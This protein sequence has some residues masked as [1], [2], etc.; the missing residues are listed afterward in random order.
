MFSAALLLSM[1]KLCS[2]VN[3]GSCFRVGKKR[4]KGPVNC[5][6][7]EFLLSSQNLC[8]GNANGG[9]Y[10]CKY[11]YFESTEGQRLWFSSVVC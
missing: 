4:K 11:S 1:V 2:D 9:K 8:K 10:P 7:R 5:G 3:L 6:K